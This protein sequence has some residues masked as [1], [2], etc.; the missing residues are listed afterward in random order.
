MRKFC[1]N[2]FKAI[3]LTKKAIVMKNVQIPIMTGT[4]MQ[5]G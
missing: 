3:V 2:E 5:H 4:V 1:K